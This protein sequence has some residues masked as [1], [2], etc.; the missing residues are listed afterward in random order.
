MR[1]FCHSV[2][3]SKY[4]TITVFSSHWS[5]LTR[6]GPAAGPAGLRLGKL[7][8][9]GGGR[10]RNGV[11][12]SDGRRLQFAGHKEGRRGRRIAAAAKWKLAHW[13]Q[14]KKDTHSLCSTVVSTIY[15]VAVLQRFACFAKQK[16]GRN[17]LQPRSKLSSQL[18][19]IT[20]Y[21]EASHAT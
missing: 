5:R 21:P 6:L 18:C 4:P 16:P 13:G 10:S 11:A 2:T 1:H 3:V 14:K 7:I 9:G 8:H 20:L 12:K 15:T 17:I 19:I